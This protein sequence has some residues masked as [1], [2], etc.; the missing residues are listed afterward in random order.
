MKSGYSRIFNVTKV[1][2]RDFYWRISF[3]I[4]C[5]KVDFKRNYSDRTF[6]VLSDVLPDLQD[7]PEM[8]FFLCQILKLSVTVFLVRII[9]NLT[10]RHGHQPLTNPLNAKVSMIHFQPHHTHT[11]VVWSSKY[12]QPPLT[13]S[14]THETSTS[15][16]P[17]PSLN[18][19]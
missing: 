11:L 8:L 1:I 18:I 19:F 5:F 9:T 7:I 6:D 10:V 4:S 12:R 3:K 17:A 15:H 13:S 2:T 16:F 14:T